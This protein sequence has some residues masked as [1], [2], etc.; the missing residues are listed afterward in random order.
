MPYYLHGN[1]ADIDLQDPNNV[2]TTTPGG[3]ITNLMIP[4]ETVPL[5]MLAQNLGLPEEVAKALDPFIRAVIETGYDRPDS[6]EWFDSTRRGCV[7]FQLAPPPEK[8]AEDVQSIAQGAQ[9]TGQALTNL[10]NPAASTSVASK[11]VQPK[12]TAPLADSQPV[13]ASQLEVSAQPVQQDVD[14]GRRYSR[15]SP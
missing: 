5:L 15:R 2:I 9:E 14:F 3:R 1:Y 13:I 12:V 6:D 10:A 8:W 11:L 4:T 7:T